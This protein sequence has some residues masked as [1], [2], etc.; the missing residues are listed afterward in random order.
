MGSP[1]MN[2]IPAD[3]RAATAMTLRLKVEQRSGEPLSIAL[4]EAR[5]CGLQPAS[6]IF[7]IRPEAVTDPDGADRNRASVV[8]AP[9]ASSRWSSPPAPTPSR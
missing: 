5:R 7:G 4:G 6:V 2:L 8:E 9:T 3:D 1:A